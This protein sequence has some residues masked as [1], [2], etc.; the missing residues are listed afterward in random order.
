METNEVISLARRAVQLYAETHPRPTQ[1]TQLQAAEMLGIS[2]ATVSRMV[3][4]G[5]LKLNRCG[6]IP[7]ELVDEARASV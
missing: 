3:K 4:A 1:V 7:I 6:M 2:R 5:Q